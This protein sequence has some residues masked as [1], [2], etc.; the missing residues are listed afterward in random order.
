[1]ECGALVLM[2][3]F[4]SSFLNAHV[5]PIKHGCWFTRLLDAH[6]QAGVGGVVPCDRHHGVHVGGLGSLNVLFVS[7]VEKVVIIGG[8]IRV[9]N[10]MMTYV[11]HMW[12]IWASY[13]IIMLI[14]KA[15]RVK[16]ICV[17]M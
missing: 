9:K 15:I 10:I 14:A 1:M 13:V 4:S 7:A 5:H 16:N 12:N 2:H 3:K 6:G 8:G 17:H 11:L